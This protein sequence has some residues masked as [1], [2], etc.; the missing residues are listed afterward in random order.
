[1]LE[2]E[3]MGV[4]INELGDLLLDEGKCLEFDLMKEIKCVLWRHWGIGTD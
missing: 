1:M 2:V 3:V 4:M